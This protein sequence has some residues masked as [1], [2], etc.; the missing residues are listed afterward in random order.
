ML[1]LILIVSPLRGIVIWEVFE[2]Q[3]QRSTATVAPGKRARKLP[4]P[5]QLK[6]RELPSQGPEGLAV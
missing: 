3:H 5:R 4:I 1:Y 2:H 6:P